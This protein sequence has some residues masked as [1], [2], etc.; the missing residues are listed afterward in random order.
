MATYMVVSHQQTG[1]E[2]SYEVTVTASTIASY[3]LPFLGL[4][5]LIMRTSPTNKYGTHLQSRPTRLVDSHTLPTALDVACTMLGPF[6]QQPLV[7]YIQPTSSS[8]EKSPTL[9]NTNLSSPHRRLVPA[10]NAHRLNSGQPATLGCHSPSLG[11]S[12]Q[13]SM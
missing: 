9:A 4:Y 8:Q 2:T 13:V 11:H 10:T 7:R 6:G 5:C 12:P 3:L 1:T